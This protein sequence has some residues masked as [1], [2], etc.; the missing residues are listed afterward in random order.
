MRQK[1]AIGLL[2]GRRVPAVM[3]AALAALAAA[4][5]S[6]SVQAVTKNWDPSLSSSAVGGGTGTWDTTTGNWF[7]AGSDGVWTDTTGTVDTASLGIAGGTVTLGS[8]VGALGLLFTVANPGYTLSGANTL[9]LGTGGIGDTSLNP[10]VTTLGAATSLVGNQ[11]WTVSVGQSLVAGGA[12][13][14]TTTLTKSGLGVLTL[15]GNNSGYSA[16]ITLNT[17]NGS[18]NISSTNAL[19]TG[20]FSI[21]NASF[22]D[23]TSGIGITNAGNNPISLGNTITFLGSS[24]LNLG[25][26]TVTFAAG[27][28]IAV[29]AGTLTLG[30]LAGGTNAFTKQG[31]GTLNINNATNVMGATTVSGGTLA[32]GTAGVLGG[33]AQNLS[34]ANGELSMVGTSAANRAQSTNTFTP[35]AGRDTVTLTAD[36][37]KNI[38]LTSSSIGA[39]AYATTMLFRGSGL[40]TATIASATAGTANIVYTAAPTPSATIAAATTFGATGSGTAGTT[41]AAVFRGGL[42][43]ASPTGSGTAFAT[44]DSTNGVR[45]LNSLTEQNTTYPGATSNDNILLSAAGSPSITGQQTNTLQIDNTS[46]FAQ[47][48]TNSGAA[49]F[50]VN[51]LLFTGNQPITLTGGTLTETFGA[52][53]ADGVILSTNTAG[54][55][56]ATALAISGSAQRGFT[57][58]GP[59]NI[60]VTGAL[61]GQGGNGQVAFNGPGT[62]TLNSTVTTSSNGIVVQG[63]TVVL[64]SSFSMTSPRLWQVASGATLD[65]NGQSV[66]NVEGLSE[67]SITGNTVGGTITNSSSTTSTLTINKGSN[68]TTARTSAAAITGNINLVVNFNASTATSTQS[69]NGLSTYTGTTTISSG[70][71]RTLNNNALPATTPLT[72]NGGGAAP[73]LLDLASWSQTVGSLSGNGGTIANNT[74]ST[75]SMFTVNGSTNGSYA[76]LI[77]DNTGAGG[78]LALAKQGLGTLELTGAN[79]YSAGT[80]LA[81]GVLKANN[82]TGSATGSGPVLVLNTG[83]LG[84]SGVIGTTASVITVSGGGTIAPGNSIGTLTVGTGGTGNSVVFAG[85]PTLGNAHYADEI[86]GSG[87]NASDDLVVKGNLD[88]SSPYDELDISMLGGSTPTGT[89][90]IASYTGTLTGTFTTVVGL[91]VGYQ[92][93]YSTPGVVLLDAVPE[94]TSLGLLSLAAMGLMCRRSRRQQRS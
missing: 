44:Y 27:R 15:S 94:P 17:T 32:L 30:P 48:V 59:G 92:V 13:S 81:A 22:L 2:A 16:Q 62:V 72:I 21:N 68:G 89:Y 33:A 40:G 69:L 54:V 85:A 11:T 5:G 67:T 91:P 86:D 56:I 79:T 66:A 36:P 26:G 14:G 3:G 55:T 23:N 51:G 18:L 24:D 50:P 7:S 74:A 57:F 49:L 87:T 9:S 88:L 42:Y 35:N 80:T 61:A 38:S 45:A 1:K 58:G 76:G 52:T 31:G 84:G 60:T 75:V 71:L 37:A 28:T 46:G 47:T 29:K 90:T 39:R 41:Q 78:T 65:M 6:S 20:T 4:A 70:I 43:D 73:S 93:D 64:G 34:L 12:L 10:V 25:T 8:N 63:G 82:L 83:L 53:V 19:G 77:A